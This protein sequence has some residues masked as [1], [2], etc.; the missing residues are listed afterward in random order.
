[1][2]MFETDARMTQ[3]LALAALSP[4]ETQLLWCLRRLAMMAP[5]GS[6][7]C[8]A[9]HVALQRN[10]GDAGMG[11]EHIL[12]CLLVGLARRA[13][14][15]L[16]IATPGCALLTGDEAGL[17]ALFAAPSPSALVAFAGASA[18][19]LLPLCDALRALIDERQR[20]LA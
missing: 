15:R 2:L 3:P 12:R 20:P 6:A 9:V 4:D 11:I 13:S 19:P 1:M 16:G 7:R 5:L 8:Q 17:L 18:A 10:F 14:R